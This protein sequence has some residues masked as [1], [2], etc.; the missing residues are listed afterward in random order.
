MKLYTHQIAQL[1]LLIRLITQKIFLTS[2]SLMLL[3]VT[4]L[5][6]VDRRKIDDKNH[7]LATLKV[8]RLL[9]TDS[10]VM[11]YNWREVWSWNLVK[12]LL[13]TYRNKMVHFFILQLIYYFEY[14]DLLLITLIYF[15]FHYSYRNYIFSNIFCKD[16][17]TFTFTWKSKFC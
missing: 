8:M 13:C 17:K 11:V 15:C 7:S 2:N 14:S 5:P 12:T 1:P 9:H 3:P 16:L 4:L 10:N 6:P